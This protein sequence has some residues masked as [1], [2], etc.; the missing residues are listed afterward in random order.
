M[1]RNRMKLIVTMTNREPR[2]TKKRRNKYI[3]MHEAPSHPLHDVT[4][5]RTR[6]LTPQQA[7]DGTCRLELG[8]PS[9]H[10]SVQATPIQSVS[11]KPDILPWNPFLEHKRSVT[12]EHR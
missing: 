6:L 11:Y 8:V 3:R 1:S 4:F 5:R 2:R 12:Y 7:T 9:A 10:P